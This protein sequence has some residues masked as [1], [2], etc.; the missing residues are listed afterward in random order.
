LK[1]RKGL[2][3]QLNKEGCRLVE[4]GARSSR[5]FGSSGKRGDCR[6]GPFEKSAHGTRSFFAFG[7][8]EGG[9]WKR[10]LRGEFRWR[11]VLGRGKPYIGGVQLAS[12]KANHQKDVR[13]SLSRRSPGK[14][15][16]LR[17]WTG[18]TNDPWGGGA[19]F[20]S[21]YHLGTR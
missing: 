15:Q 8:G 12:P 19:M 20:S 10:L 6:V 11:A 5:N 17:A 7:R 9:G 3:I 1:R 18:V 14:G 2:L 16:Y 21:E 13:R 4:K